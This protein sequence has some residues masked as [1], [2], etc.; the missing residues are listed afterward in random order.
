MCLL[1]IGVCILKEHKQNR[2]HVHSPS[3]SSGWPAHKPDS[4]VCSV[5]NIGTVC[6]QA[7]VWE[8]V[9]LHGISCLHNL[10]N[11]SE[12]SLECEFPLPQT[13]KK[14]HNS[15]FGLIYFSPEVLKITSGL[16]KLSLRQDQDP[17]QREIS[18]VGWIGKL[19]LS[20]RI[21]FPWGDSICFSS[22][23]QCGKWT[24]SIPQSL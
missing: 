3:F 5:I 13:K 18:Y 1:E 19:T 14:I 2:I 11:S 23:V 9:P 17:W 22:P 15:N 8:L 7:T 10:S 20:K 6:I 21:I 16:F 4:V 24:I 12:I